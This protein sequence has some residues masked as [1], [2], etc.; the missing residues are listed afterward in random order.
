MCVLPLASG[1]NNS[2]GKKGSVG[3]TKDDETKHQVPEACA[4]TIFRIL[5]DRQRLCHMFQHSAAKMS[6][7]RDSCTRQSRD[8]HN[9]TRCRCVRTS[10][11]NGRQRPVVKEHICH[12]RS[13]D[14]NSHH[15]RGTPKP[16]TSFTVTLDFNSQSNDL[17]ISEERQFRRNII[18]ALWCRCGAKQ[19]NLIVDQERNTPDTLA[20]RYTKLWA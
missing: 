10:V 4:R 12:S 18:C 5:Q 11:T 2:V 20:E 19:K 16:N 6:Q 3:A 7:T 13:R 8:V 17:R 1:Q 14:R 9:D 15:A